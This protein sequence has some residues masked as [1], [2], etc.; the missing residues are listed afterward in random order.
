MSPPR[1]AA[2]W[3]RD[4]G[5]ACG[6]PAWHCALSGS[7]PL[8]T[9]HSSHLHPVSTSGS[10]PSPHNLEVLSSPASAPPPRRYLPSRSRDTGRWPDP[11]T[12]GSG[13]A[14]SRL[15]RPQPS[16]VP[17]FCAQRCACVGRGKV[18]CSVPSNWVSLAN[19][20]RR[21]SCLRTCTY[22]LGLNNK[23][24]SNPAVGSTEPDSS[25]SDAS[26]SCPGDAPSPAGAALRT[27][28]P[29][30]NPGQDQGGRGPATGSHR[31]P[32]C[33]SAGNHH[34][35]RNYNPLFKSFC[36]SKGFATAHRYL[37]PTATCS[38]RPAGTGASRMK[39]FPKSGPERVA[40][41]GSGDPGSGTL[42][43]PLPPVPSSWDP[44]CVPKGTVPLPGAPVAAG[45]LCQPLA[46]R[47]RAPL[48]LFP[49]SNP[50]SRLCRRGPGRN[51]LPLAR[52]LR[53]L[54]AAPRLSR[55]RS[56]TPQGRALRG[57]FPGA[58]WPVE[59]HAAPRRGHPSRGDRF[60]EPCRVLD[61]VRGLL[62]ALVADEELLTQQLFGSRR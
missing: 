7:P 49:Q 16:C 30:A 6:V 23:G 36:L 37:R 33:G 31:P 62:P 21:G 39:P 59:P 17:G 3:V 14:L 42:P 13:E 34:Q 29:A 19:R 50:I 55:H 32:S 22:T 57:I 38:H 35:L 1:C 20:S 4:V 46:A 58:P 56:G 40:E 53:G 44:G 25:V 51:A 41:H 45:R 24:G 47:T 26:G 8:A 10:T 60:G 43:C 15:C 9:Y 48:S 11:G 52:G 2:P 12:F 27:A 61:A 18:V 5:T 54:S 28:N